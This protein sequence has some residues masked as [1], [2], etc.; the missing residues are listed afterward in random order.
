MSNSLEL[1][2][3]LETQ[4]DLSGVP[5]NAPNRDTINRLDNLLKNDRFT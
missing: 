1:D 2:Q 5:E 4:N 3:P